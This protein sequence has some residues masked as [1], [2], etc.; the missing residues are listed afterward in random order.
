MIRAVQANDAK[1][2]CDI[3]NYYISDTI[4]TFEEESVSP[5]DILTRIN[6]LLSADLP[7]FVV[8]DKTGQVIGYAYA[9]KWRE[10]FSYRFS[11]EV[12]AYLSPDHGGQ[13]LGTQLYQAL[14]T[15]L[16]DKGIHS[17]IGG[18]TLPNSASIA[19][20]EKFDM[21]KVAHFKEV[22]LKFDRWL[23]VGYWQ[24]TL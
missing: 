13:G 15:A 17:V 5:A 10:R 21:V 1:A 19:L 12:T 4:I 7:W 6:S 8:E 14:F 22:G 11:V 16:K 23:D 2:I 9:A 20:H 3:Y 18:I 24:A